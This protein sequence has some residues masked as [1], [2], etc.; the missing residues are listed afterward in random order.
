MHLLLGVLAAIVLAAQSDSPSETYVRAL[1]TMQ[2]LPQPQFV[3]YRSHFSAPAMRLYLAPWNGY[4]TLYLSIRSDQASLVSWQTSYTG[5]ANRIVL[6]TPYGQR[7]IAISPLFNPTWRGAYDWLR[8]GLQGESPAAQPGLPQ[9]QS[10]NGGLKTIAAVTAVSP[11]AYDIQDEGPQQCPDGSSGTHL[12]L[13]AR[14]LPSE[15]PLTDVVVENDSSR[16]CSMRFS[17]GSAGLVYTM[18]GFIEL[19]FGGVGKYWLVTNG[20]G[21]VAMQ[22]FGTPYTHSPLFF[23]YTN[24]EFVPQA[25]AAAAP[26]FTAALFT[27]TVA[28]VPV[29]STVLA[30]ATLLAPQPL[31]TIEH[32]TTSAVCD[33]L[34][35]NVARAIEGLRTNDRVFAQA[36]PV[37]LRIGEEFGSRSQF[38]SAQT[39]R[40]TVSTF[41]G[42]NDSDPGISMNQVTL[43]RMAG[44]IA[45]NIEVIQAALNDPA[46][47]PA[48]PQTPAELQAAQVNCQLEAV[49]RQQSQLLNSIEGLEQTTELQELIAQGDGMQGANSEPG[50]IVGQTDT[51]LSYGD[52]LDELDP[53]IRNLQG[54]SSTVPAGMKG[55]PGPTQGTLPESVEQPSSVANNPL[56]GLYAGIVADEHRTAATEDALVTAVKSAASSCPTP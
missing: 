19:H 31:K 7:L 50:K 42:R 25:Q 10:A 33:T 4:A 53:L 3:T 21:D 12:H 51:N 38:A 26:K 55:G 9:P 6:Q 17:I 44:Q 35:Q 15:H 22:M 24:A 36:N 45:H 52:P 13:V 29:T 20:A 46:R 27:H 2:S 5:A 41:G 34:R 16:F 40:Q 54:S 56:K 11:G 48:N 43:E 37:V 30:T 39:A 32:V 23:S 47:F 8:F 28:R 18:S 1:Q 14:A 49:L